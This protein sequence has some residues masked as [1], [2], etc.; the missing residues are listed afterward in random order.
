M[1]NKQY[2]GTYHKGIFM[3][4]KPGSFYYYTLEYS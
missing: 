1:L 3:S 2:T 4:G